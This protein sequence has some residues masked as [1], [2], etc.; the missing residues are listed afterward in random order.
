MSKSI[1]TASNG[2]PHIP[3]TPADVAEF[4]RL[5]AEE[6]NV[7]LDEHEAWDRLA[8]LLAVYRV[9]L[10]PLPEDRWGSTRMGSDD[11]PLALLPPAR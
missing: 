1:I 8:D 10:G 5:V 7:T 2:F 3:I 9:I 11:I 4:R 6:L